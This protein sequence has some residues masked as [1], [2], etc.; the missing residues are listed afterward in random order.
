M[1]PMP[2]FKERNEVLWGQFLASFN[3][4]AATSLKKAKAVWAHKVWESQDGFDHDKGQ[5]S[6]ISGR[7]L[8]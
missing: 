1:P 2:V 6:A 5:K 4:A 3:K 8:H 7:R